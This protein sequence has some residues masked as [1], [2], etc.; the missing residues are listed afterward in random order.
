M[1]SLTNIQVLPATDADYSVVQN[2][3]SY[4]TYDFTEY[5]GMPC[6][7]SGRFDGGCDEMLAG[8]K[9]G[10]SYLFVIRVGGELAGFAAVALDKPE[11]CMQEFFI[12]RKFRRQGVGQA[13]AHRLFD[14]FAGKWRVGLFIANT[15]AL[16]FWPSAIQQYIGAERLQVDECD[17]PWGRR[18]T[19][20]FT[21]PL[22]PVF[23]PDP[24]GPERVA[25]TIIAMLIALP[26]VQKIAL[27]GSLAEGRADC[28]SNVDLWVACD[29]V[30]RTQWIAASAIR[31][32][33]PVLFY[34]M[35][36]NASQPTGRYW[37]VDE[38]P[39]H[40][41]DISF[42]APS[43]YQRLIGQP[44]LMGYPVTFQEVFSRTAA[45]AP[46][47][48]P[49]PCHP[50]EISEYEREIGARIYFL[51]RAIKLFDRGEW[52]RSIVEERYNALLSTLGNTDR[53]AVMGGGAIGELAYRMID[54][55][56][57]LSTKY[58]TG[59]DRMNR[60]VGFAERTNHNL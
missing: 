15:P 58:L 9:A 40:K 14:Q 35:F 28:W 60:I 22:R 55:M 10:Y 25:Q 50:V 17:S 45:A 34:R 16:H 19:L 3:S 7:E 51:Q 13:V 52:E 57:I 24:A 31:A 2:L 23:P 53:S 6:P 47:D 59:M 54:I 1:V 38:S 12:L 29:D 5:L 42:H 20:R 37:F 8:W 49:A 33:H 48:L 44:T 36:G 39:F 46:V 43:D 18:Q 56:E 30:E 4:Y 32:A 21:T 27:F 11:Y 41:I 26:F